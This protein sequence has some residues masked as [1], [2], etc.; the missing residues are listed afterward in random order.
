[1][2]PFSNNNNP[3]QPPAG[4]SGGNKLPVPDV[5]AEPQVVVVAPEVDHEGVKKWLNIT[6]AIAGGLA[7]VGILIFGIYVY[8]SNTPGYMLSAALQNFITSDGDAGTFSYQKQQDG[9]TTVNGDF[10]GYVDPSNPHVNTLTV[11]AGQDAS[12]V[13]AQ[14]RLFPDGNFVQIAG[15]GNLGRL[16]QNMHGDASAFTPENSILLSSY[17]GR[18]YTATSDDIAEAQ[19]V[20]PQHTLQNGPT[21][22]DLETLGQLY[23]KHQ[24]LTAGQNLG[25]EQVNS[26]NTMRLKVT[27]DA[28]KFH[29]F[30]QA[31][32]AANLKSLQLTDDDIQNI[33]KSSFMNGALI[34]AWINRTDRTFQQ[35]RL[36]RPA[37][38]TTITFKSEEV[39]TQRQSV[40]QPTDVKSAGDAILKLHDILTTKPAAK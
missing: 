27:I 6:L 10:I 20:L 37:D 32:K 31:L 19:Q 26:I 36:T 15:L 4:P 23:L 39:A 33:E 5:N 22:T 16:V 3:P 35:L 2:G 8:A 13:S 11:N 28:S 7:A 12:R 29:D 14:L 38:I 17:D 25:D 1:M 30:L 18:W 40:Q 34:E 21:S 24:F 9:A